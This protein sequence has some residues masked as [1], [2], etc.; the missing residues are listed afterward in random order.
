MATVFKTFLNDDM[1]STRTLL[2]EAIPVSGGILFGTY[3]EPGTDLSNIKTYT[4]GMFQSVYDYSYTKSSANHI[5]DITVGYSSATTLTIADTNAH[6]TS[7]EMIYNEFAKILMGHD[8][9]GNINRLDFDGDLLTTLTDKIDECYVISVARLL[10]KDE[11]KKGSF[12]MDLDVSGRLPLAGNCVGDG[13]TAATGTVTIVHA[14][15][16]LTAGDKIV[17]NTIDGTT[18]T[19]TA[20]ATTTTGTDTNNPTFDIVA[21]ATND[22]IATALA[23]CL[24]ANSKISASATN[25]VVTIT[26]LGFTENAITL[27]P[28]ANAGAMT[29]TDFTGGTNGNRRELKLSDAGAENDY[30]VNSPVGDYG[31]LKCV[32]WA[33]YPLDDDATCTDGAATDSYI[34]ATNTASGFA[35]P[36]AAPNSASGSAAGLIFYQAGVVILSPLVFVSYGAAGSAGY[37]MDTS[38]S[39]SGL[40]PHV[41]AFCR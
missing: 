30:R 9:S 32:S 4:H 38:G 37:D 15:T 40:I 6:K 22:G 1:A 35:D 41:D 17:F 28:L 36:A 14:T 16:A 23:A 13:A 33:N 11:I 26:Q 8:D 21:V 20:S 39:T 25:A 18:I 29:K 12:Y 31:I 10:N 5:F 34:Y 24:D 27:D 19:A 7:K 2:H 3:P